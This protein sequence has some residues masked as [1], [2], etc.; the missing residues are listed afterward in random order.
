VLPPAARLRRRAEFA[1]TTRGGRRAGRGS[2]VVH[3]AIPAD[4]IPPAATPGD[5]AGGPARA[6]FTVSKAVGTAVVRNRVRRRLRHLVAER[7]ATLPAGACLVVRA[8]PAAAGRDYQQLAR[9]LDQA[10]AAAT[11]PRR[12]GAR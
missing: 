12:G 4:A 1:A 2:L 3:L 5:A 9:D 11:A 8:L 10:L 7:L 6:G